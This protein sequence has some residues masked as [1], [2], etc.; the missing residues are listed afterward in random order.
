MR[1]LNWLILTAVTL[2]T[3]GCVE[4]MDSGYPTGSYGYDNYSNGYSSGYYSASSYPSSYYTRPNYVSN[5]TYVYNPPPRVVTE[6]RYVPVPVATPAPAPRPQPAGP[7]PDHRW[8]NHHNDRPAQAVRQ[9]SN[10]D[11]QANRDDS[12]SNSR[13]GDRDREGDG[14]PD[15][16]N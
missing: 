13:R 14:R 7:T 3:A 8:D 4:S 12:R 10:N 2:A 5:N 11:R 9:P 15:R 16:R 1:K 6:T